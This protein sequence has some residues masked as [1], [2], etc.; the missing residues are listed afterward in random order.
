M[1]NRDGEIRLVHFS[2]DFKNRAG[3]KAEIFF[4]AEDLICFFV[5][6]PAVLL[7]LFILKAGSAAFWTTFLLP[8]GF[9]LIT[10]C[11]LK[12]NRLWESILPTFAV[13]AALCA[14]FL[15]VRNYA[16][17]AAVFFAMIVSF[18]KTGRNFSRL[19]EEAADRSRRLKGTVYRKRSFDEGDRKDEVTSP[20]YFGGN[21]LV[22]SGVLDLVAYLT[23]LGFGYNGL[24]LFC[25]ADFAVVFALMMI[26]TQKSGAYCLSLWDKI[27]KTE[28]AVGG[29]KAERAGSALL[30]YFTAVGT[31]VIALLIFLIAAIS[32][33]FSAD[34]AFIGYL[35]GVFTEKPITR[36]P[37]VPPGNPAAND[38][39]SD[40]DRALNQAPNHSPAAEVI[41]TILT[42]VM[43]CVVVLAAV[44]FLVA[45]GSAVIKFY[46]KLNLNTNEESRS[47]LSAEKA[48][49]QFRIHFTNRKHSGLFSRAG[50]RSVIRRLFFLHIKRRRGKTVKNSDTPFELGGKIDDGSDMEKAVGIYEKARYSE[51]VCADADVKDMKQALKSGRQKAAS[52]RQPKN[53]TP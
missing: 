13:T 25:I 33:N 30:S 46:R 31:A 2:S 18:V 32:G 38:M 23:A 34:Q 4:Y 52:A 19:Y 36:K 9:W 48:A 26:Y 5:L 50:N 21:W 27:S 14:V 45:I 17:A 1:K 8:G 6:L 40:L 49:D 51:N 47:L 12:P 42:V 29:G 37:V 41:K 10:L 7:S 53:R 24:A 43:W 39:K 22:F 3:Q 20:V 11:R 15:A 16:A 44:W 35:A 28:D